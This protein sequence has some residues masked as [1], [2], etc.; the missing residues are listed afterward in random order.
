MVSGAPGFHGPEVRYSRGIST[1]SVPDWLSAP[2][3]RA[4]TCSRAPDDL[5]AVMIPPVLEPTRSGT[6]LPG[7]TEDPGGQPISTQGRAET[8]SGPSCRPPDARH[9]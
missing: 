7:A 1:G 9:R 8:R 2:R 6:S 4:S 5:D 3:I